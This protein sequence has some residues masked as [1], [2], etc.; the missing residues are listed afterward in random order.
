MD[1]PVWI[2][3][4]IKVCVPIM[5][6]AWIWEQAGEARL[7]LKFCITRMVYRIF[8]LTTNISTLCFLFWLSNT[9]QKPKNDTGKEFSDLKLARKH[10]SNSFYD[11][12]FWGHGSD[13]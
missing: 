8:L 7:D 3:F 13:Y 10:L 4:N 9:F 6:T 12:K 11:R 5:V 2:S 1:N